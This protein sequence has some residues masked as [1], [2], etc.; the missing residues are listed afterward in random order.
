MAVIERAEQLLIGRVTFPFTNYL[1]NRRGILA[2]Y[3]ELRRSEHDSPERQQELQ[4]RKLKRLISFAY[5][6]VPFYTERFRAIGLLPG[7][8][9]SLDDL[10]RIPPLGRQDVIDHRNALVDRMLEG[11]RDRADRSP[12]GPGEP[13]PFAPFRH[14]RLV[15]NTSSGSTGAPTVFY[16]DGSRT[17]LNW[18]HEL[19][20]KSWF[21]NPPGAREARMVRL[22]TEYLPKSR[23]LRLRNRLWN[24]L[25]LPGVN[26]TDTDYAVCVEKLDR[27]R[28]RTLWGFT[29]ALAGFA[30]YLHRNGIDPAP[31]GI[32][33][34]VGW[35]A[36]VYDHERRIL[37]EVFRCPVSNIYGAREVGH[38]AGQCPAGSDHINQEYLLAE[39]DEEADAAAQG[40]RETGE[41]LVTTLDI[42]PMPFIRYRMGDIGRVAP[43]TCGCGRTLPVLQEFLGRTGEIYR[44]RDGRMISP[45]FWCR[46]F[47]NVRLAGAIRR[48]QV[49]YLNDHAMRIK[50]V[51]NDSY[52]EAT[53]RVLSDHLRKNFPPDMEVS[54]EYVPEIPPQ[55]SG[56]YQ[57]V[58]N[59]MDGRQ[60]G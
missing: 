7:D 48:F 40:D 59:A 36:P 44:T 29:S 41:I 32:G 6:R 21:G 50:I 51:R 58:V 57:M 13:I 22:S 4:L 30:D 49:V 2:R 1:L 20:L 5:E 19:R 60:A 39:R 10:K 42:S 55:I 27:F 24:Q 18:V 23:V 26:L 16:E 56:K 12:R 52:T 28:P 38:V 9:A 8:I 35:A 3:D 47:M 15:R 43:S 45:N 54:F 37:A 17:A 53:E 14:D 11:S 34:V 46:T 33:V 25:I 31:W